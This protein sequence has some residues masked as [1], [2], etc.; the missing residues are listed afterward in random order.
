MLTAV[1]APRVPGCLLSFPGSWLLA[2]MVRLPGGLCPGEG[3]RAG[4][5]LSAE[6]RGDHERAGEEWRGDQRACEGKEGLAGLAPGKI[7]YLEGTNCWEHI[8]AGNPLSAH[9]RP[10]RKPHLGGTGNR[11]SS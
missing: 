5:H 2:N 7:Y 6:T 1:V 4:R 10:Q 11:S 9:G 3:E 8:A